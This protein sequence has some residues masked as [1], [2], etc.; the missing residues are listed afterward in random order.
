MDTGFGKSVLGAIMII[1]YYKK[2]QRDAVNIV[3]SEDLKLD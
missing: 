1:Y 3:P 2:Y